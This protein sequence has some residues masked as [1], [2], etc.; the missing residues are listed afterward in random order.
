M[1]SKG[2]KENISTDMDSFLETD[3]GVGLG[4]KLSVSLDTNAAPLEERRSLSS[5]IIP[6]GNQLPRTPSQHNGS[7]LVHSEQDHDNERLSVSPDSSI[8]I[9]E[10]TETPETSCVAEETSSPHI[11][12]DIRPKSPCPDSTQSRDQ[13]MSSSLKYFEEVEKVTR[14]QALFDEKQT[15]SDKIRQELELEKRLCNKS[16]DDLIEHL[17]EEKLKLEAAYLKE[18]LKIK[19]LKD[20]LKTNEKLL[21]EE[22][23]LRKE[24]VRINE[25][26][27]SKSRSD[28]QSEAR[29]QMEELARKEE[30]LAEKEK[31]LSKTSTKEKENTSKVVTEAKPEPV[32]VKTTSRRRKEESSVTLQQKKVPL[33]SLN[34]TFTV[35][36]VDSNVESQSPK[37]VKNN[38][39]KRK[40]SQGLKKVTQSVETTTSLRATR[41]R[42]RRFE[43]PDLNESR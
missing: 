38:R 3:S 25:D 23:Q 24:L 28:K 11:S 16:K 6:V 14:L 33:E 7:S 8:C 35:A 12:A 4:K 13:S 22:R 29:S 36:E 5:G 40:S 17:K 20:K 31:R 9:N 10:Y 15:E 34:G 27:K 42:K 37:K 32:K 2:D 43:N 30:F 41:S 21:D 18:K 39:V 1:K 19:K 26:L